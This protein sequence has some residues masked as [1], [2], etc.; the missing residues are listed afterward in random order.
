VKTVSDEVVGHSLA[1]QS[2]R[3]WSVGTSPSTW[4]FGEYWPTLLQNADFQCIFACSAL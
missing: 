1:Y 3:I 2:V 4:K